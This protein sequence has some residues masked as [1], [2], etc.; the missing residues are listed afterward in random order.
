[1]KGSSIEMKNAEW[2]WLDAQRHPDMQRCRVNIMDTPKDGQRFAVCAFRYKRT[3]KEIPLRLV[4][5]VS[6]DTTF[7]F[8]CNGDYIGRGPA[9]VG[10]DFEFPSAMPCI[11]SSF[12]EY[13]PKTAE[14]EIYAEVKMGSDVMTEYSCGGGGFYLDCE[15]IYRKGKSERF[16]TGKDWECRVMPAF[17]N[18]RDADFRLLPSEWEQAEISPITRKLQPAPIRNIAEEAVI[19]GDFEPFTVGA[20]E[21]QTK[22]FDFD[23]IYAAYPIIAVEGGDDTE[24]VVTAQE[25]ADSSQAAG[26]IIFAG[27]GKHRFLRMFSVGALEISVNNRGKTPVTVTDASIIA[28]S[29]PTATS[30]VNEKRED[31]EGDFYCSDEYLNRLYE[32]CRHTARICRQ[33]LHLDSPRHQETLACAGDY[34]VESLIDA[35]AFGD[36]ELLALILCGSRSF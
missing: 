29:Y 19:S 3:F 24:I 1:M 34:L 6:G 18:C 33:S 17:L 9:A 14:I 22:I 20:G 13:R 28:V 16:G 4:F 23:R 12:Y 15:V 31:R 36:H 35:Y 8:E 26:K 10:G 21:K 25:T 5:E 7:R 30:L 27:T 2:I 11:Y 32:L